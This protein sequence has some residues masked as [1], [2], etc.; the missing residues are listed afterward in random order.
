MAKR[1]TTI[2]RAMEGGD[3]I[4]SVLEAEHEEISELMEAIVDAET[5]SRKRRGLYEDLRT[6]WM[7]HARGEELE[8]YAECRSDPHLR[9]MADESLDDHRE[10]EQ[11]LIELD[12][13]PMHAA[14]WLETFERLQHMIEEHVEF[15]ENELFPRVQEYFDDEQLVEIEVAYL[16]RRELLEAEPEQLEPHE[17]PSV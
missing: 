4:L 10:M 7:L 9:T 15:E 12:R 1:K 17:R 11:L 14:D 3:G 5:D 8:F 16:E 2:D 6:R 13:A